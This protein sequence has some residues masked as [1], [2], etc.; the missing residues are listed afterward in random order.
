[1]V[2]CRDYYAFIFHKKSLPGWKDLILIDT[3]IT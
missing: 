1:M 3:V 2:K